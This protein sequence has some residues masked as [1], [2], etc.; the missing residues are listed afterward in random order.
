MSLPHDRTI[1]LREFYTLREKTD[2]LLE[3]SD[4]IVFMTPSPS[5]KHQR[6]SGRLHAKLFHFLDGSGCE[7]FHAPFD[8]ELQSK[9]AEEKHIVIPDLL[10]I[11]NKSGL[12]DNKFSGAP[13]LIIE[14]LSPSN[15]SH[16]L[17]YKL[18][19]YM[20]A[21]VKE[22]WIVNPMLHIIQVYQLDPNGQYQQV[23]A[24]KET[25][26][27]TSTILNGFQVNLD[28]IFA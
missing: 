10:V 5:T 1:S 20:Q 8:V 7:V 4:G 3:Y 24:L 22:Y 6:I 9:N 25:G 23:D 21:G 11:C 16:D 2:D 19:L 18:N 15:Q 12:S 14:I 28:E 27:I 26:I 13:D 17:V